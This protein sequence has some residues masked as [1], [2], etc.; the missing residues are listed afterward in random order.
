[1]S[2]RRIVAA[3]AGTTIAVAIGIGIVTALQP[4]DPTPPTPG[5]STTIIPIP[6][7]PPTG[8][9]DDAV[10]PGDTITSRVADVCTP[11]WATTHRRS[12]TPRQK[13]AVLDAYRLPAGTRVTEWDHRIPL[14][15]GGGNGTKNIWPMTDRTSDQ[16]K[17]LLENRLHDDVCDGQL[18]L[19]EAQARAR[20]YW[21]WW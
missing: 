14:E 2:E 18:P 11:G 1:M 12:L 6:D 21:K 4:V 8:R 3:A 15:L 5:P 19:A 20:E 10:T 9:P 13:T 16:R 17:D 7:A